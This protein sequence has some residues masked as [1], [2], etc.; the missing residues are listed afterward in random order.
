[1]K[2]Q[3]KENQFSGMTRE[4]IILE[5][6]RQIFRSAVLALA[7]LIVIG[8]AC[9]AW[10]ANNRVVTANLSAI[11]LNADCFELASEGDIGIFDSFISDGQEKQGDD[12]MGPQK[13]GTVTS[14][15]KQSILWRM[16]DESSLG[17]T[18]DED[19][20]RPGSKGTLTFYVLPKQTGQLVLE[21][22]LDITAKVTNGNGELVE[23]EQAAGKLL[24]GHLLFFG[25]VF[26]NGAA[27]KDD[28][29]NVVMELIDFTDRTFTLDFGTVNKGGEPIQVTLKWDWPYLLS[30]A[31]D[32]VGLN[33][34]QSK[35]EYFL[36]DAPQNIGN[37]NVSEL[38]PYYNNADQHIGEYIDT[39]I[40]QLTATM[41]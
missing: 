10:F 19:G 14:V 36:C 13:E 39:I 20:I 38:S 27:K 35:P 32:I 8:V 41:Q 4:E 29:N 6:R 31:V 11:S 12:W 26:E 9:Y 23:S 25:P 18:D 34:I 30:D 28:E 7:A 22:R 15:S 3:K 21:F 17:N 16:D 33:T 1:M 24:Q 2:E 37:M 5:A 40:L